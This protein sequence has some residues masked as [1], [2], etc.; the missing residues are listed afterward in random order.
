MSLKRWVAAAGLAAVVTSG[1][2]VLGAGAAS[3]DS[4]LSTVRFGCRSQGGDWQDVGAGWPY[5]Y[6]CTLYNSG[7][8]DWNM[9]TYRV[10]GEFY[11]LYYGNV[12]SNEIHEF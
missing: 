1:A 9:Y 6:T 4:S 10:N 5:R 11:R 7:T 2:T 3:A 12:N 8:G